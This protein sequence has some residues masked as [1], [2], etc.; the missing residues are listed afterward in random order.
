[1]LNEE[2]FVKWK[3]WDGED[4]NPH[5]TEVCEPINLACA[6]LPALVYDLKSPY[7]SKLST[8]QTETIRR[9]FQSF[10]ARGGFLLGD[11]TGVGKGRTIAGV[12]FESKARTANF[13]S[14]WISANTRLKSDSEN[15]IKSICDLDS[16]K[17]NV[18]FSSYT[19]LLNAQNLKKCIAFLNSGNSEKLIILDECHTLR[20]NSVTAQNIEM[21]IY[22][23][24]NSNI[25]YSSATAA[26]CVKH[27]EY[28]NRLQLWGRNTPF[29]TY[30]ALAS[31][32]RTHGTPLMEL[33]SIQMR[34][35]GSYVSRQLS[36]SDIIME[37]YHV[38]LNKEE[39][40][41]YNE[42]TEMLRENLIMG[43]SAHQT[44][45]QKIMTGIKTK[46][47]IQ[48]AKTRIKMGY[49]VV[50]SLTNTGEAFAK[51]ALKKEQGKTCP[52]THDFKVCEE[53][54]DELGYDIP[55]MPINPIDEI[56]NAF[57]SDQVAE[58]TGRTF[59]YEK[60]ANGIF[61]P[62]CKGSLEDEAKKFQEGHKHIAI[63]SRA[64]GVGI[65]LHDNSIGRRRC[66]IILEM[67]WSAEDFMQQLGRTH[68]SNSK[69][70]P[71][72]I[73]MSTDVP[74]EMRFTSAIIHKLS[75]MGAL[76]RGDRSCC[77]MKW[78]DAP[79]WSA[80]TRRSI[81]L[82]L[83]TSRL[84][85]QHNNM[86]LLEFSRRRALA[87]CGFTKNI[88]SEVTLKTTLTRLLSNTE[89][90]T[91]ENIRD[92][93]SA[94]KTLYPQDT[95]SIFFT[96]TPET[97]KYY[98]QPFKDKIL[99]LLLCQ[100]AW[101]TRNSLGILPEAII[102]LII[103][104]MSRPSSLKD[105]A[106]TGNR[107]IE[108]KLKLEDLY[109]NTT[110]HILNKIMG[111]EI[112]VQKCVTAYP[113]FLSYPTKQVKVS[114]FL[115][116][117]QE[118]AGQNIA[119]EIEDIKLA[120]FSEGAT[121]VQVSVSHTPKEVQNPPYDTILWK[122]QSSNR[123]V[124]VKN[125]QM[126]TSDGITYELQDTSQTYL[127]SKGYTRAERREWEYYV[128]KHMMHCKKRC[129]KLAKNYY[130]ATEKVMNCWEHSQHRVLRIPSCI[131]FPKGLIGLLVFISL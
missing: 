123:I 61:Q 1:M 98:P 121:G 57:G 74:S 111:M 46:Y 112:S 72:Y 44:F 108:H 105:A 51:R 103:E 114:C 125:N 90:C 65:S 7:S 104:Y 85:E 100:G 128:K 30:S 97:H 27:L 56:L 53:M 35:A 18:I 84:Y 109:K 115:R 47:A 48:I 101:E 45:F 79:K 40:D 120:S 12:L 21:L 126:F 68:R 64:G 75:S 25:L 37:H 6:S 2:A 13:R 20:N 107:F 91:E 39:V 70:A 19:S 93:L 62:Y 4:L 96:W 83:A 55:N 29:P 42:C 99:S 122:H 34:S 60:K 63:L 3:P 81:G 5:P 59:T 76:I 52:K 32:L 26:S 22:S 67:P 129:R 89:E 71:Y 54:L 23:T 110:E 78:L 33:L 87:I 118:K 10:D 69:S 66:H 49:S 17:D 43:G 77:D 88:V 113:S 82:Y 116:F 106:H 41:M 11:A 15:E 117:I 124:Y 50:I 31:A 119:C 14:V 86:T 9:I 36:F 130:I 102:H 38:K 8:L 28:L 58:L 24:P 127:Q 94:V 95:C 73:L 131:H 16:L 80:A 92:Y